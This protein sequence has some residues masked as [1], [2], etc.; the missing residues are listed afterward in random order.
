MVKYAR[1]SLKIGM[2]SPFGPK[3]PVEF[4]PFDQK[5]FGLD[6]HIHGGLIFGH[7]E[8]TRVNGRKNS[9]SP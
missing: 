2:H 3:I 7:F 4:E 6:F 5:I 9:N 8:K 1:M